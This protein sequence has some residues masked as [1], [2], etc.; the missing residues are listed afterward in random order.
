MVR[1]EHGNGYATIYAHASR[2]LVAV[3]EQVEKGQTV[4]LVGNTGRSFGPHLHFEI[5]SAG[6][7]LD[8]LRFFR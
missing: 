7:P 4:A 1:I 8:P 6:R 2:L 3:N 5:I